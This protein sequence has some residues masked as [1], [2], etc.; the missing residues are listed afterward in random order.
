VPTPAAATGPIDPAN[1][2]SRTS[3]KQANVPENATTTAILDAIW[4]HYNA[5]DHVIGGYLSSGQQYWK[6]NYHWELVIWV[7]DTAATLVDEAHKASFTSI[8][9]TLRGHTPNPASGYLDDHNMALVDTS[10]QE[11]FD[12]RYLAV[13]KAK[14]DLAAAITASGAQSKVTGGKA[15]RFILS[16]QNVLPPGDNNKHGQGFSLDIKGSNARISE[17]SKKLGATTTYDEK[18]HVHV[19][20]KSG[21]SAPPSQ[22]AAAAGAGSRRGQRRPRGG[23]ARHERR[24]GAAAAPRSDPA[25]VRAARRVVGARVHG[26]QRGARG[27]RDGRGGVRDG[28][29]GRVRGQ[30]DVAHGGARGGAR[31]ATARG[32]RA[33]GRRR[34]GRRRVRASRRRRRRHGRTR[35]VGGVAAR[36]DG[37]HRRRGAGRAGG[38]AGRSR[39]RRSRAIS[40]TRSRRRRRVRSRRSWRSSRRTTSPA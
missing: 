34:P 13:K 38:G 8:A 17:T 28:R 27:G 37:G 6:I 20:F 26:R 32:R 30:P 18:F 3:F 2:Q 15:D 1:H 5:G 31:G 4:P 29:S 12:A 7:C 10:T 23:G 11:A 9:S 14:T 33:Q 39:A 36:S 22:P 19:E 24:S 35:R 40:P 21:V 25:V 16:V